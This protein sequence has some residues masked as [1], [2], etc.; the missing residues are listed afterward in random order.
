MGDPFSH[1]QCDETKQA[2]DFCSG[3]EAK[4]DCRVS[5]GPATSAQ[6]VELKEISL[7]AALFYLGRRVA[8]SDRCRVPKVFLFLFVFPFEI[9]SRYSDTARQGRPPRWGIL[10]ST[11]GFDV[12]RWKRCVHPT[13]LRVCVCVCDLMNES[14]KS[15]WSWLW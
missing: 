12:T 10:I 13:N 6:P 8:T 7:A 11:A 4:S 14:H 5:A 2:N 9:K 15:G 1:G 3:I